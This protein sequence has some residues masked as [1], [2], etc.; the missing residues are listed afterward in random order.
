MY[1]TN[2]LSPTLLMIELLS[3]LKKGRVVRYIN[4]GTSGH[5]RGSLDH[6]H[7]QGQMSASEARLGYASSKLLL[8]MTTYALQRK[9]YSVKSSQIIDG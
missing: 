4:V 5:S 2:T 1:F 7:R 8:L 9:V 3:S 6:F